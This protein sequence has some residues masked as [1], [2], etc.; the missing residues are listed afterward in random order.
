[1][2]RGIRV[3]FKAACGRW[4]LSCA[5]LRFQNGWLAPEDADA[6]APAASM[7]IRNRLRS[8]IFRRCRS[9][10]GRR[11]VCVAVAAAMTAQLH[12]F[13]RFEP[14]PAGG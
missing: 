8:C 2:A 7:A 3:C 14:R 12:G 10:G 1:M 9:L 5:R 4:T 11:R 13:R 6:L